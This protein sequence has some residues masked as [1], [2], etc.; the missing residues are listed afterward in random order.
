VPKLEEQLVH[1]GHNIK[2][3]ETFTVPAKDV[4]IQGCKFVELAIGTCK[5]CKKQV[6]AYR[7]LDESG[8]PQ[9]PAWLQIQRKDQEIWLKIVLILGQIFISCGA[10]Y[11]TGSNPEFPYNKRLVRVQ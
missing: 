9:S 5:N 4:R 6:M 8:L 11:V 1:C 2:H 3:F 7:K 10:L